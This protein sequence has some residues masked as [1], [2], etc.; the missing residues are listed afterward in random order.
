[1]AGAWA[2][3][4]RWMPAAAMPYWGLGLRPGAVAGALE[5]LPAE[6]RE[7]FC[8]AL[9]IGCSQWHPHGPAQRGADTD[10]AAEA[11]AGFLSAT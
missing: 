11:E 4:A 8:S 6:Q 3:P 10:A 1:M 9:Q 7:L 5:A 2:V